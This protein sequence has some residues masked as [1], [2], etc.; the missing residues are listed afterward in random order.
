MILAIF[1]FIMLAHYEAPAAIWAAWIGCL[2]L[3]T[4]RIE[5]APKNK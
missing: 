5:K 4:L 2:F 3:S 1:S